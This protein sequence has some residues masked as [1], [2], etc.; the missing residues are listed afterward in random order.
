MNLWNPLSPSWKLSDYKDSATQPS[1]AYLTVTG[2][3]DYELTDEEWRAI[4][5]LDDDIWDSIDVVKLFDVN[6][7]KNDILHEI[8]CREAV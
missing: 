3:K 7:T 6:N 2:L 4:D 5:I 8:L 1:W